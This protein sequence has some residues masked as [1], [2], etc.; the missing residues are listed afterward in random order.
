[1]ALNERADH[2]GTFFCLMFPEPTFAA[3]PLAV[4]AQSRSRR[5]CAHGS[6]QLTIT[7]VSAFSTQTEHNY[8]TD[9]RLDPYVKLWAMG[10]PWTTPHCTIF[11]TWPLTTGD[12]CTFDPDDTTFDLPCQTEMPGSQW[13]RVEM[14]DYDAANADDKLSPSGNHYITDLSEGTHAKTFSSECSFMYAIS[15]GSGEFATNP[16]TNPPTT[17]PSTNPATGENGKEEPGIPPEQG[18]VQWPV[19]PFW[20]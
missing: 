18:S 20:A 19:R 14:W 5:Q 2:P 6:R 8:Y 13:L 3:G 1:M 10:T 16:P 17:L 12:R 15:W 11:S 7:I 4:Q 9:P